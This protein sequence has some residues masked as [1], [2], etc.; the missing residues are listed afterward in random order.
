MN[1]QI[2]TKTKEKSQ[3]KT[4]IYFHLAFSTLSALVLFIPASILSIGWKLFLLALLYQ[5]V[6][7]L[8]FR[9]QPRLI[10][11]WFFLFPLSIFQVF[12]DWF[13]SAQLK[14]LVFPEDGFY[15]I[16]TVSGYM[17][18][19]WVIPLVISLFF[20]LEVEKKYGFLVACLVAAFSSLLI[21]AI[22]EETMWALPSWYAR[23]VWIVGHT[24]VYVL[25]AEAILG[26]TAFYFFKVTEPQS[27]FY[28]ILAAFETMLVYTGALM[29]FYFLLG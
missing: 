6:F 14:V 8:I 3:V 28:K 19:L 26:A 17:A 18:L 29:F 7:L 22:A 13:L 9:S 25:P 2:E 11:L 16:G 5:P 10:C 15:K 12:P 24:A 1:Q 20:S 4:F 27:I 21:F 23:D